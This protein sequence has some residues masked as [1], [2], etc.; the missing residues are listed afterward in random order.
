M[1]SGVGVVRAVDREILRGVGNV[2]GAGNSQGIRIGAGGTDAPGVGIL[3]K[4]QAVDGVLSPVA[5]VACRNAYNGVR[6]V[7][8]IHDIVEVRLAGGREADRRGAKGQVDAVAVQNDGI[9]DGGDV[10]IGI[11][12]AVLAEHLHNDDLRIGRNAD[13]AV[14]SVGVWFDLGDQGFLHR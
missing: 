10:V 5:G 9:L 13:D 2:V 3:G 7:Q 8:R 6:L 12:A 1:P 11:G 4:Q 14:V